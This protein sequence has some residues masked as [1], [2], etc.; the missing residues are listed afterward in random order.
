TLRASHVK[1]ELSSRYAGEKVRIVVLRDEKRIENEV[2]LIA[3]L[4]PYQHPFLGVLPIRRTASLAA[5]GT[6][7]KPGVTVRYV[8][9]EGPAAAAGVQPGDVLISVAG[10]SIADR[11]ELAQQIGN[12]EPGAEVELDIRRG[13]KPQKMKAT[14]GTLPEDLPAEDLPEARKPAEPPEGELPD[15][16]AVE[17]KVPEMKNDA[18]AYVPEGYNPAVAHG[19]VVWLHA[20]GGFDW[21]KLLKRWKP[22]C[23]R[24]DLILLAPK[25]EDPKA[26]KPNEAALAQKLLDQITS[27]YTVDP[28]RVVIHG[29]E[30]GGAMACM[31][32]FRQ[33]ELVRAVAVVDAPI[34]GRPP[35]NDPLHRL[36]IY[37]T[38]AKK[39]KH[40]AAMRKTIPGLR[41]M[42]IP[43][44]VKDLGDDP[45]YLN[46]EELAELVRWIDTLDRI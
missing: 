22:L 23:D 12:F 10:N 46:D 5:G 31:V 28:A 44:T 6:D 30:G 15:V 18:W 16:G 20:P 33:R 7:E 24:H 41:A 37:L 13:D 39:S 1:R 11:D 42:K 26:W 34:A 4:Q 32:A 21:D 2:E 14:L 38:T 43:V 8:Y 17:M 29:H 35:E 45:R 25:A 40:A 19:V 27:A 3:K 9:P 36:A